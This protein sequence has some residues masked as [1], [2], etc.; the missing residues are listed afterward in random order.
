MIGLAGH[1]GNAVHAGRLEKLRL[2][3]IPPALSGDLFY[4]LSVD[5][6][7]QTSGAGI[8]KPTLM[9]VALAGPAAGRPCAWVRRRQARDFANGHIVKPE[10]RLLS[11]PEGGLCALTVLT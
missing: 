2:W 10:G 9:I 7:R 4:L 5:K 1:G 8:G 3:S 6:R 11:A